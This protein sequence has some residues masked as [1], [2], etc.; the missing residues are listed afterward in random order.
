MHKIIFKCKTIFNY[1]NINSYVFLNRLQK[2][3]FYTPYLIHV[4]IIKILNQLIGENSWYVLE[5]MIEKQISYHIYMEFKYF[6]LFLLKKKSRF[7]HIK[8]KNFFY[9]LTVHS[10]MYEQGQ[11]IFFCNN[12]I[13]T[14]KKNS[15]KIIALFKYLNKKREN[16]VIFLDNIKRCVCLKKILETYFGRL[17]LCTFD[18]SESFF[19]K[20]DI[21]Y[22]KYVFLFYKKFIFCPTCFNLKLYII[23][24]KWYEII[25]RNV[26]TN[27]KQNHIYLFLVKINITQDNF[28]KNNINM[29]FF[30]FCYYI[31]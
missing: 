13:C 25:H 3:G 19:I 29:Y 1:Y 21:F 7:I 24:D 6:F 17:I 20:R 12:I 31:P 27:H 23:Y 28:V 11:R 16:Y 4:K 10:I 30:Y 26:F 18:V 14:Y 22:K 5:N 15:S 9:K 8:S 2:H